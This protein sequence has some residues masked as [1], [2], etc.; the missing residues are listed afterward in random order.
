[1][2]SHEIRK[3][4]GPFH[5]L[6]NDDKRKLF[7]EDISKYFS[8]TTG[9]LIAAGIHKIK[10]KKQYKDPADPYAIS[11]LFCLERDYAFLRDSGEQGRTLYCIFEERGKNEDKELAAHFV[12]ICSGDNSWGVLPF[13]MVFASKKTN[14]AGL[15]IA[16][17]AAY[18]I[19]Q[20]VNDPRL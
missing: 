11:M 2:H 19:A 3:R 7:L 15:Q 5:I 9:T 1:F 14:M 20:Y 12:R 16:D 13:E 4:L 18:P 17:L 6:A 10:H 8:N